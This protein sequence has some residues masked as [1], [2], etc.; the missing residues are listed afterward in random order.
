MASYK[1]LTLMAGKDRASAMT[2][3]SADTDNDDVKNGGRIYQ[4]PTPSTIG[5]I[6][7]LA[8]NRAYL[9]D[10]SKAKDGVEIIDIT[11]IRSGREK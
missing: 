4:H 7:K 6:R 5:R 3:Y 11:R 2:L 10:Q 9:I 8:K 1:S